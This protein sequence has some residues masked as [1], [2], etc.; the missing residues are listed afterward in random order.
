[1]YL[2]LYNDSKFKK[3]FNL[4][5]NTTIDLIVIARRKRYSEIF[6]IILRKN[7]KFGK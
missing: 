7:L 3:K 2:Y 6:S 4:T 5:E 1:M